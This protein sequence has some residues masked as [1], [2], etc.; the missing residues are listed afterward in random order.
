MNLLS[1]RPISRD[2]DDGEQRVYECQSCY[3]DYEG[4]FDPYDR[5]DEI[6]CTYGCS[7]EEED[8]S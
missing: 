4:I 7:D 6:P 3:R 1:S 8:E 2:P 5:Q